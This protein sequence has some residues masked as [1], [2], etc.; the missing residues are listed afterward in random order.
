[1]TFEELDI[2]R[3]END[4]CTFYAD[5]RIE[6]K[7]RPKMIT[8]FDKSFIIVLNTEEN[9]TRF[10]T[11]IDWSKDILYDEENPY[12]KC[13]VFYNDFVD[14]YKILEG[15]L[16]RVDLQAKR[17]R[18][19]LFDNA[20]ID[21]EIRKISSAKELVEYLIE[22]RK[23]NI[24]ALNDEFSCNTKLDDIILKAEQKELN[25]LADLYLG[26]D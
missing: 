8:N 15:I 21:E 3:I 7:L 10:D 20:P 5:N 14:Y 12:I 26:S 11:L 22:E 6:E 16:L 19:E 25:R 24:G 9:L 4:E 23:Y 17:K 2:V 13:N 18:Q 1:M